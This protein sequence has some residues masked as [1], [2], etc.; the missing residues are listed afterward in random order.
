MESA[1]ELNGFD[2]FC[3]YRNPNEVDYDSILSLCEKDSVI[4]IRPFSANKKLIDS[5]G[6]ASLLDYSLKPEAVKG[7]V[8]SFSTQEQFNII[9]KAVHV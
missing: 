8:L 7:A 6:V 5:D 4:A 3:V 9:K 2:G 1:L